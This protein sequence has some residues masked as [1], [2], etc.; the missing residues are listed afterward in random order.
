INHDLCHIRAALRL[1]HEWA[2][3]R[4]LPRF[5]REKVPVKAVRFVTPE[6]FAALYSSAEAARVPAGFAFAP[7]AWWRALF[8]TVYMTGWRIG[9]VLNFR[10]EDLDLKEARALIRHDAEGNKGKRDESIVLAPAG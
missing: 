6:H 1:A 9:D 2:Y 7:A 4:D 3:L 5:R 8:V 10:R